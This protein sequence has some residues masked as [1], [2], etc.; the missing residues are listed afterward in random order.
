[1]MPLSSLQRRHAEDEL[2]LSRPPVPDRRS[3]SSRRTSC[4]QTARGR[5]RRAPCD[6]IA[7]SST[8]QRG[9]PFAAASCGRKSVTR[10]ARLV[11]MNSRRKTFTNGDEVTLAFSRSYP[12]ARPGLLASRI[13]VRRRR[14]TG[15]R[16]Q[17]R[18]T[19][20][21]DDQRGARV[22][23][24]AE[25]PHQA[26]ARLRRHEPAEAGRHRRSW[27]LLESN[28]KIALLHIWSSV[29]KL[30]GT[31]LRLFE[32]DLATAQDRRPSRPTRSAASSPYDGYSDRKLRPFAS[33]R[34]GTASDRRIGEHRWYSLTLASSNSARAAAPSGQRKIETRH[35]ARSG[36][37]VRGF[38]WPW[39][40][41]SSG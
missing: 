13:S 30:S 6:G 38:R 41:G 32:L 24:V 20:Q 1:M 39:P 29:L 22:R 7:S 35:R 19:R 3:T 37:A 31:P 27:P 16:L 4:R 9:G 14:C 36:P 5:N 10:V 15:W 28:V 2:L 17:R 8:S 40:A 18:R 23:D 12:W 33:R 34:Y 25:G 21:L 11:Q 26:L